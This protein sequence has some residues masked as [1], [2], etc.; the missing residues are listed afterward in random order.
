MSISA[1][2]L[3]TCCKIS[4]SSN[5]VDSQSFESENGVIL[6]LSS[7]MSYSSVAAAVVEDDEDAG[8]A[9]NADAVVAIGELGLGLGSELG[10][11]LGV[12]VRVRVRG[13]GRVRRASIFGRSLGH[14]GDEWPTP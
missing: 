12:K 1:L 2:S 10:L 3:Q 6:T 8:G 9:L 7:L 14:F 5:T 4:L 13:R 11:G